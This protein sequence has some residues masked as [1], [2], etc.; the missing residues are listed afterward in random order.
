MLGA[1]LALGDEIAPSRHGS[2]SAPSL[3]TRNAD[4]PKA[5]LHVYAT[6]A[7]EAAQLVEPLEVAGL[8][9]PHLGS[10]ASLGRPTGCTGWLHALQ[11]SPE[12]SL[13]RSDLHEELWR[14]RQRMPKA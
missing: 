9:A 5:Q 7:E 4:G 14:H 11:R 13:V 10:P 3:W 1:R 8:A 12:E 2:N 6:A